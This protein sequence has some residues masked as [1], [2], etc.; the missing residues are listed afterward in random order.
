MRINK[1]PTADQLDDYDITLIADK[2]EKTGMI[3]LEVS[4]QIVDRIN[5]ITKIL[6]D[7]IDQVFISID[8][9]ILF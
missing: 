6:E 1:K 7:R 2:I 4:R 9:S 5:G 3:E 8:K